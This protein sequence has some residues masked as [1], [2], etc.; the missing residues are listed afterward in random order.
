[1]EA[2]EILG[3]PL[4]TLEGLGPATFGT[5]IMW[6]EDEGT[7]TLTDY[8]DMNDVAYDTDFHFAFVSSISENGEWITG[9]GNYAGPGSTQSF[10]IHVPTPASMALMGLGGLVATRRRR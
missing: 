6:T 8:L 1:M 7:M 2:V 9:W 3:V 10:V 4:G 5:A